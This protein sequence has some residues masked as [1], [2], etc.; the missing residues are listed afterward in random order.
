MQ[1]EYTF[2]VDFEP[3]SPTLYMAMNLVWIN[4]RCWLTI[5]SSR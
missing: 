1:L 3:G 4:Y 5:P 2:L